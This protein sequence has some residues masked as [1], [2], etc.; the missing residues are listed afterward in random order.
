MGNTPGQPKATNIPT[1]LWDPYL[2]KVA[3]D[4][5][6]TCKWQHNSDPE[7]DL[8]PYLGQ[9]EYIFDEQSLGVGENLYY[10]TL[11]A[12]TDNI[13]YGLQLYYEEYDFYTFNNDTSGC[14]QPGEQCGHYTQLVWSNTRYVGCG[15]TV[16]NGLAGM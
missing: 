16:C 7:G 6:T 8:L 11:N 12:S 15:Y 5:S 10:T 1:L 3:Q 13:V 14:C 4:Y 9:T 2:A